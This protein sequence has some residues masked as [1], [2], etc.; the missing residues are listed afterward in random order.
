MHPALPVRAMGA[1]G[2]L[3]HGVLWGSVVLHPRWDRGGLDSICFT[4]CCKG[5]QAVLLLLRCRPLCAQVA[6]QGGVC[7]L[8]R[9]D[10]ADHCDLP[11][12]EVPIGWRFHVRRGLSILAGR[13]QEEKSAGRATEGR[14]GVA[15]AK[16]FA[17]WQVKRLGFGA[18][19]SR[20]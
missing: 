8:Q 1:W 7:L 16:V 17:G 14:Q 18:G 20:R 9:L 12:E 11:L 4:N 10:T 3:R 2:A 13:N 5:G 19:A 15:P 6:E